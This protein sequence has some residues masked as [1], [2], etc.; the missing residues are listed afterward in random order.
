MIQ[1]NFVANAIDLCSRVI[2]LD[3]AIICLYMDDILIF[4]TNIHV[5]NATKKLMSSNF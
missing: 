5:V 1:N 3:C 2:D 4:G